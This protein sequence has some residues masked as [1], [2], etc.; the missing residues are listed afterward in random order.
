MS[1]SWAGLER[2]IK[3]SRISPELIY[4]TFKVEMAIAS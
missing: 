1:R 2:T 3:F 4:V